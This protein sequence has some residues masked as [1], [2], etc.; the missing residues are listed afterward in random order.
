[1]YDRKFPTSIVGLQLNIP[2]FKGF[3]QKYRIKQAEIE[4]KKS[5]NILDMLK[6][7]INLQIESSR[8]MYTNGLESLNNQKQNMDLARE[9]LRVT[10]IKYE[11]GVGSNIE[12]TQAQTQLQE[13]ENNYIQ[14]L[15][16]ALIS[17]VDLD[18]AYGNIK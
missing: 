4:I 11:Q 9:V 2:I 3:Q 12:V 8:I 13:S 16:T 14:A 1:L 10:R 17:K 5:D 18:T 15:Y 6:N 7:G